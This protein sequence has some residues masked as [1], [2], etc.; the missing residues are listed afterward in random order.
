MVI[1]LEIKESFAASL[2][3]HP[4][5]DPFI[6]PPGSL[7]QPGCSCIPGWICMMPGCLRSVPNQPCICTSAHPCCHPACRPSGR[8]WTCHVD[9]PFQAYLY[10]TSNP[11]K[12]LHCFPI[13]SSLVPLAFL[14]RLHI[15]N[16]PDSS[17]ESEFLSQTL[18]P[19]PD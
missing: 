13:R 7:C 14:E 2:C 1:R 9:D 18:E 15:F 17:P 4:F 11:Y 6:H 16:S 8:Q 10:L 5:N 19:D 3:S 12:N